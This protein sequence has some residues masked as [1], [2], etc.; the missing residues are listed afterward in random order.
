VGPGHLVG[1]CLERSAEVYFALLAVLKAGAAYVP[2]DPDYPPDRVAGILTDCK[3]GAIITS[4]DLAVKV[5]EWPGRVV[6][7]DAGTGLPAELL[8]GPGPTPSDLA[9]VI[10]TSGSTGR[11][12]GVMIEHKSAAHLVGVERELYGMTPADRV[13]QGFSVAFD[14]SVEEVW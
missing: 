9:Y 7:P 10:Y 5:A 1:I 3:A 11:P 12:K 13:F 8:P 2:L 14:A 4:P 6:L